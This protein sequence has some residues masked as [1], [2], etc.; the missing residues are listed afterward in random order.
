MTNL[1]YRVVLDLPKLPWRQCEIDEGDLC[2]DFRRVV[3]VGE[4]G[5]DV[6]LEVVVV[7]NDGISQLY[8]HATLLL[9]HLDKT[10]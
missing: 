4:L 8:H 9:K 5:C 6:E 10:I 2:G 7:R 1:F 3:G